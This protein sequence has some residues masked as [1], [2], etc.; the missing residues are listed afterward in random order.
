MPQLDGKV[1]LV[2]GAARGIGRGCA[3]AL[4]ERGAMVFVADLPS[5]AGHLEALVESDPGYTRRLYPI[6]ADAFSPDGREHIMETIAR[7]K[8][9]VD[10][11]VSNPC[12]N[13]FHSFLEFPLQ[14][15][16]RMMHAAFIGHI[17]MAQLIA[18]DMIKSSRKG[19]IIF[20]SSV[21]GSLIRSGALGYDAG[22]AALNHAIRGIALELAKH[23]ITVNGV[24]P[25]FTDTP[26]ERKF[27]SEEQVQAL[28]RDLPVGRATMPEDIGNAVAF[29]ASGEAAQITGQVLTVD[30]G[31][32]LCDSF[33]YSCRVQGT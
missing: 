29:L 15:L 20:T 31:M 23:S 16:E 26:G 6:S 32:S 9:S 11:L 28:A 21:M 30:G 3:L 2:T 12:S 33:F 8:R 17:G 1:A 27:L 13:A 4:A 7:H 24:A 10:I 18:R 19:R 14:E 22:K 5:A 25:G